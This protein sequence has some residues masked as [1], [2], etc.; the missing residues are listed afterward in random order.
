MAELIGMSNAAW[1][2]QP[3]GAVQM[4]VRSSLC[5]KMSFLSLPGQSKPVVYT[6]QIGLYP[7]EMNA[8]LFS[9][10][11]VVST[12]G[13]GADNSVN[14]ISFFRK[15]SANDAYV[16]V[17]ANS[18]YSIIIALDAYGTVVGANPGFIRKSDFVIMQGST[19]KLWVRYSN[20]DFY[21]ASAINLTK[22]LVLVVSFTSGQKV[23]AAINNRIV[24]N[25]ATDKTTA[26]L[27]GIGGFNS[28]GMNTATEKV[29]GSYL[30]FAVTHKAYSEYEML[31]LQSNPW[32][33][34]TPAPSRFYLIPSSGGVITLIVQSASHSH[35]VDAPALIQANVLSVADALHGH[36][37]IGNNPDDALQETGDR[38]LTEAGDPLAWQESDLALS[39]NW[40]LTVAEAA[41]SHTAESPAL[42]QANTI[43]VAESSHSHSVESPVLFQAHVLSLNDALHSHSADPVT[44]TVA[45]SLAVADASHSHSVDAPSMVQAN[46]LTIADSAHSHSADALT[47]TQA[48]VLA[49]A[50][51]THDHSADNITLST[52]LNLTVADALHSHS[53]DV[54]GLTQAHILAVQDALHGHTV[55]SVTMGQ[56]FALIVADA[57][58]SHSADAPTV[59]IA[60]VLAVADALHSQAADELALA[61]HV[62]LIVSD[63]FHAHLAGSASEISL[64]T[65]ER[66]FLVASEDRLFLVAAEDRVFSATS[67]DRTFGV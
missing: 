8:P 20:S 36:F 26:N 54:F 42:T 55:E 45:G 59:S 7:A 5:D 50:D 62:T 17:P 24:I 2:R 3:S 63:A 16:A 67:E 6:N 48:H 15:N 28:L 29:L 57:E 65:G 23:A 43:A 38:I 40:N 47:L 21:S 9:G 12:S 11:R 30:L 4:N 25:A 33:L 58:H 18:N 22:P 27:T 56:G 14:V 60:F 61:T 37:F 46:T 10:D 66:V 51:A 44:L 1:K 35:S 31:D 41:H 49:L 13:P 19:G 53:V 64:P 32:Q 39:Q 34:F 52:E